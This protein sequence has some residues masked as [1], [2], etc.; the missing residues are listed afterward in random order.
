MKSLKKP[1]T[2]KY[3]SGG[4][5]KL[6]C[7]AFEITCWLR[8]K[9]KLSSLKFESSN[10]KI[11]WSSAMLSSCYLLKEIWSKLTEMSIEELLL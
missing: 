7:V 10:R 2:S 3:I 9:W 11:F 4:F 5:W 6:V 1:S 8:V